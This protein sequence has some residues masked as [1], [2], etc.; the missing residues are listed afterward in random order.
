M[1]RQKHVLTIPIPQTVHLPVVNQS[2]LSHYGLISIENIHKHALTYVSTDGSQSAKDNIM[3][4]TCIMMSLS[5]KGRKKITSEPQ[6][7]HIDE[8]CTYLSAAM[9]F[10]VLINHAFVNNRT[11]TTM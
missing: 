8:E 10:K 11:A 7:N 5:E 9:L 4:Y 1:G 3:C 2:L 6:S